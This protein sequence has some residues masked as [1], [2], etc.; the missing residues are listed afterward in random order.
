MD[1]EPARS[2]GS[3]HARSDRASIRDCCG[4]RGRAAGP[5]SG[6]AAPVGHGRLPRGVRGVGPCDAGVGGLGSGGVPRPRAGAHGVESPRSHAIDLGGPILATTGLGVHRRRHDPWPAGWYELAHASAAAVG[7]YASFHTCGYVVAW[8]LSALAARCR[9]GV[10]CG[11]RGRGPR[12]RCGGSGARRGQSR[13]RFSRPA[14]S[15]RPSR[16]WLLRRHRGPPGAAV[17]VD[18]CGAGD[19]D[20]HR[21][22][23]AVA[24]T[25]PHREGDGPVLR[26]G[27]SVGISWPG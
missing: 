7:L 5:N 12:L 6:H 22:R 9:P 25:A 13:S 20:G 16:G 19:S 18:R 10:L 8:L 11:S 2:A 23:S 21:L 3:L 26:P 1:S 24:D 27:S 4:F 14:V 17:R 15:S